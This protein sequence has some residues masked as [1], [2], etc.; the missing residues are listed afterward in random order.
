MK[1]KWWDKGKRYLIK[2]DKVMRRLFTLYK[3]HLTTRKNFFY[4]L[5]RSIISSSDSPLSSGEV[6]TL[7]VQLCI[8]AKPE[9]AAQA[10]II[11]V[12]VSKKSLLF[13]LCFYLSK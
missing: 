9:P 7:L 4:S 13:I 3:G 6:A 10:Q 8:R 5:S 1:P 12:D 2:R 11:F